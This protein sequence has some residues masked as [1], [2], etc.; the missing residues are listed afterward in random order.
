MIGLRSWLH[1]ATERNYDL[2]EYHPADSRTGWTL[3]DAAL[4][5]ALLDATISVLDNAVI[6]GR[7]VPATLLSVALD[8]IYARNAD[9]LTAP[10]EDVP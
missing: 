10:D 4:A 7:D 8:D 2:C 6:T 1:T 3:L 9:H 5:F